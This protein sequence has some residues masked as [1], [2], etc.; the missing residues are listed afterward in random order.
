[1]DFPSLKE[2][3]FSAALEDREI[4]NKLKSLS[5]S[6]RKHINKEAKQEVQRINDELLCGEHIDDIQNCISMKVSIFFKEK[7]RK[8]LSNPNDYW[9]IDFKR[10]VARVIKHANES[11]SDRSNFFGDDSDYVNRSL[12]QKGYFLNFTRKVLLKERT[13]RYFL[14]YEQSVVIDMATE[15]LPFAGI[16]FKSRKAWEKEICSHIFDEWHNSIEQRLEKEKGAKF[17][18]SKEHISR[19]EEAL[20]EKNTLV[21]QLWEEIN[22]QGYDYDSTRERMGQKYHLTNDLYSCEKIREAA[23]AIKRGLTLEEYLILRTHPEY[24][25]N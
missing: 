10:D 23:K 8:V 1:M 25:S 7:Q 5:K 16:K 22:N 24:S 21:S 6:D 20:S 3:V 13:S 17:F 4:Y 14:N 12:E 2:I 19:L 9:I 18:K 11:V 15:K